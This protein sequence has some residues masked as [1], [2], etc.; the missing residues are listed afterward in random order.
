MQRSI[1][2]PPPAFDDNLRAFVERE[3]PCELLTLYCPSKVDREF[4]GW[5]EE[6]ARKEPVLACLRELYSLFEILPAPVLL[7]LSTTQHLRSTRPQPLDRD[8]RQRRADIKAL[9]S[10]RKVMQTYPAVNLFLCDGLFFTKEEMEQ[11]NAV[12]SY[13][14][15]L[16]H[17][18]GRI[19]PRK[20][21]DV[22]MR[23]C[24]QTLREFF[25]NVTG[26]TMDEQV[27]YLLVSAFNWPRGHGD[28]RLATIQRAKGPSI[29][30]KR[31]TLQEALD[32]Q[33]QDPEHQ[34]FWRQKEKEFS[35]IRKKSLAKMKLWKRRENLFHQ[36]EKRR[37]KRIRAA[38]H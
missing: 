18:I 24:A 15:S 19:K 37:E 26:K 12:K 23:F 32:L 17:V 13:L 10:A 34:R 6:T 31:F 16:K 14:E 8:V 7:I 21:S 1:T 36:E 30:A 4:D 22:T 9:D 29:M 27:G 25:R 3:I 38:A 33:R 35:L 2:K 5:L 28:L 11:E 20:Q